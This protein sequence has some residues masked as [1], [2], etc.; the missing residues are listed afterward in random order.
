M[1]NDIPPSVRFRVLRRDGH[2]CR[3]CGLP[4]GPAVQLQV[5]HLIPRA[6]G[7][8]NRESNLVAA[9]DE[10]NAG[11]G[12]MRPDEP[13]AEQ[14][15]PF[16]EAFATAF[17]RAAHSGREALIDRAD[18][19]SESIMHWGI[20]FPNDPL[21]AAARVELI[22]FYDRGI[23]MEEVMTWMDD[24]AGC[25]RKNKYDEFRGLCWAEI[26]RRFEAGVEAARKAAP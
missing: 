8:S 11:K 7:G 19:L 22:G 5:E 20:V 17:V 23:T 6:L 4:A 25:P 1:S 21:P 2:A 26:G 3:Y 9:C 18:W 24:A 14:P 15:D 16:V 12:P 10:C 13:L